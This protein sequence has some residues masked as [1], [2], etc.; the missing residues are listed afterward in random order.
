[1]R[2]EDHDRRSNFGNM[3]NL[4]EEHMNWEIY[5]QDFVETLLKD[6]FLNKNKPGRF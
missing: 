3:D 6:S 5:K 2:V 4:K 1:M